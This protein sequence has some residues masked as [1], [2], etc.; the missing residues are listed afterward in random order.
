M[1]PISRQKLEQ[2]VR[3]SLSPATS[4]TPAIALHDIIWSNCYAL[5]WS[6]LFPVVVILVVSASNTAF[7]SSKFWNHSQHAPSRRVDL[8]SSGST[9]PPMVHNYTEVETIRTN[10][11]GVEIRHTKNDDS[12]SMSL[13][14]DWTNL[15]PSLEW[16]KRIIRHQAD[17]S[18]PTG[19]FIFRNRF[20]L[21][22][23]L[24]VYAQALCNGMASNQRLQTVGN[25]TWMDATQ[26]TSAPV[27]PMLCYFPQSEMQCQVDHM[28]RLDF[29]IGSD[30]QPP[31]PRPPPLSK[32]NGNV[33]AACSSLLSLNEL[34]MVNFRMATIEALFLRTSPRVQY[35]AERQLRNLFGH[36]GRIP[37]DLITVHIRWGDKV[38]TYVGEKRTRLPEMPKVEI[39]KYIDAI[40]E[41]LNRRKLQQGRQERQHKQHRIPVHHSE[42]KNDERP[43]NIYLAT[44]DPTALAEF[45]RALPNGWNLY[46]DQYLM[47]TL[48]HRVDEYNGS[49]KMARALQGKAGL[50]ALG[51]LLVAMEAN[52]FV[53]T[54]S[55]NWSRLMDELRR[56]ILDPRCGN[57]TSIIDLR[58]EK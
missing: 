8:Y 32:P 22:S 21:G 7:L 38:T 45:Q 41:I 42:T 44:E 26:C 50:Y 11:Q 53:L 51:S 54:T 20:G 49:S 40:H 37:A 27:S 18:L 23:D 2:H 35:E 31:S 57:C 47:E 56:S 1:A 25:W 13:R 52:D 43:V 34:D 33:P 28:R 10:Y 17:C 55:S 58:K 6:R 36:L 3:S 24:H 9:Y 19:P 39:E 46:V 5:N 4:S 48:S 29:D 12:L 15:T 30:S 14:F 16:T